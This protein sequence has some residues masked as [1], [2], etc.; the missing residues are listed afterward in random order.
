MHQY[1]HFCLNRRVELFYSE[2]GWLGIKATQCNS[3]DNSRTRRSRAISVSQRFSSHSKAVKITDVLSFHISQPESE[4]HQV[5]GDDAGKGHKRWIFERVTETSLDPHHWAGFM[6]IVAVHKTCRIS[7]SRL[8]RL[9]SLRSLRPV[10]LGGADLH[11][12]G[13]LQ[14]FG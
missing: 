12:S 4:S 7:P 11:L 6:S 14:G 1:S 2:G 8:S 3:S 13:G 5:Q 10:A 9:S